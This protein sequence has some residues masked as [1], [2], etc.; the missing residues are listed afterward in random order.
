M[1]FQSLNL[2]DDTALLLQDDTPLLLNIGLDPARWYVIARY[3]LDSGTELHSTTDLSYPDNS[4]LP[5][6]EGRVLNWGLIDRSVPIPAGLPQIG[7]ARIRIADTD[8]TW[9]D[10]L[11]K[12]TPRRRTVEIL[13]I[14]ADQPIS[15]FPPVYTGQVI[16]AQFGLAYVDIFLRDITFA[17][18]DEDIPALITREFFP[19]LPEESEGGFLPIVV[20]VNRSPDLNPQGV[21]PA[22]HMYFSGNVSP[23]EG[24]GD[25]YGAAAHP[26]WDV[27]AVY[28]KLPGE[29]VFTVVNPAEFNITE[30]SFEA[31][32]LT[33]NPTFIDFLLEQP[34]GT[35]I[36]TDIDGY[37]FRGAFGSLTPL[38]G[39]S[40]SPG[41]PLRNPGDFFI[42]MIFFIMAKA[43]GSASFEA[44][45]IVAVRNRF[46]EI[47]ADVYCDGAITE[48]TKT[49][50]FL[51]Q[52]LSSF[53]MD[54]YQNR[55][56]LITL[57]YTEQPT[58]SD[59]P[60][61]TTFKE[62]HLFIKETFKETLPDPVANQ[63]QFFFARDY[64]GG[65][66]G[67]IAIADNLD[68]QD[69][70]GYDAPDPSGGT[71]RVPVVERTDMFLY[72]VRDANVAAVTVNRKAEYM[73]MGS[74]RQ[75]FQLPA[76]EIFDVVELANIVAITHTMGMDF[77]TG[78]VA[79][80]VKLAALSLNLDR[81]VYTVHSILRT[82]QTLVIPPRADSIAPTDIPRNTTTEN[83]VITGLY[84][85]GATSI[86]V[87]D[88]DEITATITGVTATTVTITLEIGDP[89]LGRHALRVIATNGITGPVYINV[90]PIL[91][92][93]LNSEPYVD[94]ETVALESY[95]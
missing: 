83:V 33:L 38:D 95:S 85:S 32:G 13:L 35:E 5:Y 29:A 86:R 51:A 47:L 77:A 22:P 27:T 80:P 90:T 46:E 21:I 68:D 72:F 12:Q 19:S 60:I 31:F 74:Y 41:G 28:R 44:E 17:W 10:L 56:G 53:E 26:V 54:M 37:D 94:L 43:G 55:H 65:K 23:D 57:A 8:R 89:L 39:S 73:S 9:R 71:M 75:E 93:I 14:N 62:G 45:E 1:P 7:D 52:F 87:D 82:K 4:P 11:S 61:D 58:P 6:Y 78:Y 3:F 49:R 64:A 59:A 40:L 2:Q 42:S 16:D 20:G 34:T 81:L 76:P 36:R 25:R 30:G 88:E 50:D 24:F 84:L 92:T 48:V 63:F 69:T 91:P 18:L 70:L 79:R 67:T 15:D 66:W